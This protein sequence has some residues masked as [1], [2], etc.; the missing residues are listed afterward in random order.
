MESTPAKSE[1]VINTLIDKGILKQDVYDTTYQS[2]KIF[3]QVIKEIVEENFDAVRRADKRIVFEYRDKTEFEAEL[4]F[5]GDI[6]IFI[7]H[8]NIF[9]FSRD[10]EVMKTSY[11]RED[12]TQSYCGMITLFN[13]LNDSFK[14]NRMND[15]GYL[16]GR[17]FINRDLHYFIEGKRE[18]GQLYHNFS[19]SVLDKTAVRE[20]VESAMLYTLNFDLLTP[21]YDSMKEVSVSEMQVTLENMPIKTGKRLGFKFY[22]DTDEM[23]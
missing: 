3:K 19:T 5:G 18:V 17:V 21:P 16:I 1:M 11:I 20:I 2:F 13:F 10:H 14:Y 6:L 12:P 9:E 7:M 22:A 15:I 8:T 4:K 23:K